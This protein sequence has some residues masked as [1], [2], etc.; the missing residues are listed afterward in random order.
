MGDNGPHPKSEGE[1]QG[2]GLV[3]VA[4][5][6]CASVVNFFLKQSVIFHDALQGFR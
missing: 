6:V 3:E 1:Y 5:K 4:C 2:I